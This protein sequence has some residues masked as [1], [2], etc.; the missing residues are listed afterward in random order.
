MLTDWYIANFSIVF[1]ALLETIIISWIYG[2]ILHLY[3]DRLVYRNL[4][5]RVRC[6]VEDDHHFL[7][8]RCK[9]FQP[10]HRDDDRQP[11][12]SVSPNRLVH[13]HT[14][15]HIHH[16]DH[17]CGQLRCTIAFAPLISIF[18][19]ASSLVAIKGTGTITE[20]VCQL[21]RPAPGWYPNDKKA[22]H[23]FKSKSYTY[24]KTQLERIIHDVLGLRSN[25]KQQTIPVY[26]H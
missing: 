23:I 9:P 21:S 3:V 19:V 2:R 8:I 13:N 22:E 1:V 20:R 5:H 24:R 12:A 26:D 6:P 7:D 25:S 18:V 17:L 4:Q 15:I 14:I 16:S 10:R 11:P